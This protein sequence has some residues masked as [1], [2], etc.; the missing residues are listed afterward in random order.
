MQANRLSTVRVRCLCAGAHTGVRT[1]WL[2]G[3]R[4]NTFSLAERS[5]RVRGLSVLTVALDDLVR[6]EGLDRVDYLKIDAEGAEEEILTGARQTIER[7][8]PII[9]TEISTRR[10]LAV[11][12]AYSVFQ[13]GG[14]PNVVYVPDEHAKIEVPE[15]LGWRRV[16]SAL[17]P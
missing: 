4:P 2:N 11:L 7:S 5:G 3:E 6:W 14:S 13:A 17:A 12:P 8:R 16:T 10:F 15:R 1:L 9:Q